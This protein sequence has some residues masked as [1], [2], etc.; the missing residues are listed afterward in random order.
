MTFFPIVHHTLPN[1]PN[2]ET[3]ISYF[4]F[5]LAEKTVGTPTSV[6]ISP[7]LDMASLG[8][9]S[10]SGIAMEGATGGATRTANLV[11]ASEGLPLMPKQ[12]RGQQV[13]RSDLNDLH[14]VNL[15]F[16]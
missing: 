15:S 3:S 8:S 14:I 9:A 12:V 11:S 16:C 10:P 4:I 5:Q 7:S 13:N 6:V 1:I 2:L